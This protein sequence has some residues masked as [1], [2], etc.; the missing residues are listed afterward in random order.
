[1]PQLLVYLKVLNLL[2]MKV[3][4]RADDSS[5]YLVQFAMRCN[6]YLLP[7]GTAPGFWRLTEKVTSKMLLYLSSSNEGKCLWK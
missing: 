4:G 2:T 7:R 5:K 1:M 3:S 6:S